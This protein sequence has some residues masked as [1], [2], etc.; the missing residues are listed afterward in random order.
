MQFLFNFLTFTRQEQVLVW[1]KEGQILIDISGL[2]FFNNSSK[3][4]PLDFSLPKSL[5]GR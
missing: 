3:Q 5:F 1:E 4:G 2:Y